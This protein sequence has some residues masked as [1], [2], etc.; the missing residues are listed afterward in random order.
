MTEDPLTLT[1]F[2]KGWHDYHRLLTKAIAPLTSDHLTLSA[3][4]G[5][6]SI[7]TLVRHIIG[8]RARWFHVMMGRGEEEFAKRAPWDSPGAPEREAAELVSGLETSW[9][10][11]QEARARWTPADL[12]QNYQNDP[13]DEPE[14]FT[15]QW[16][17]WHL[18]EHDL[19]HG[20]EIS[21]TLGMYGLAALDL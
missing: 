16:V 18:I 5:L 12:Q 17:I 13:S 15:R 8:G 9:H 14:I 1:V 6:R 3:A 10:V 20:G 19:H 11:M 2:Y 21:L 7:G 4:P